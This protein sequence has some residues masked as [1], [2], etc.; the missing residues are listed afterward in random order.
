MYLSIVGRTNMMPGGSALI[1]RR[2]FWMLCSRETRLLAL[3]SLLHLS[4]LFLCCLGYGNKNNGDKFY[5]R[6][7]M[8]VADE[9]LII[10][11]VGPY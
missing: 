5:R 1:I 7:F 3:R 11:E 9:K 6:K 4:G 8:W 10:N 2:F